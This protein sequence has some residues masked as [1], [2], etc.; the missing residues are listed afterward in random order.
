MLLRNI[1]SLNVLVVGFSLCVADDTA[2]ASASLITPAPAPELVK[3][4]LQARD[5][6]TRSDFIGYYTIPG[7]SSC[8]L[9][10]TPTSELLLIQ[11]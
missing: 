8:K 4:S 10:H 11:V 3:K 6:I 7:S 2:A 9:H 1:F 5:A